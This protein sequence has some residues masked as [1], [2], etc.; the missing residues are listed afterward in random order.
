MKGY[1]PTVLLHNVEEADDDLGARADQDLALA[2]LFGVVDGV[3][4]IVQDGGLHLG[5]VTV[6]RF[7]SGEMCG[8]RYLFGKGSISLPRAFPERKE[9]PSGDHGRGPERVLQLDHPPAQQYHC[10]P[11]VCE[12]G[13]LRLGYLKGISSVIVAAVDIPRGLSGELVVI[14]SGAV[15]EVQM[16]AHMRFKRILR[17]SRQSCRATSCAQAGTEASPPPKAPPIFLSPDSCCRP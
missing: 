3:E 17:I 11:R 4:R 9:C 10:T 5:G 14:E 6:V 7:S 16:Q 13:V 8:V 1:G 15:V 12:A 2:G